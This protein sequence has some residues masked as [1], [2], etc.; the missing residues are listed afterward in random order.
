MSVGFF[1]SPQASSSEPPSEPPGGGDIGIGANGAVVASLTGANLAF[2]PVCLWSANWRNSDKSIAGPLLL[3]LLSAAFFAAGSCL[4]GADLRVSHSL[5]VGP[6]L[7]WLSDTALSFGLRG[8]ADD[9]C[10]SGC[11]V[12]PRAEAGAGVGGNCASSVVVGRGAS[13]VCDV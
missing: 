13:V 6:Y 10:T 5:G 8:G 4:S 3:L 7:G 2:G 9:G 11:G 12:G 1:H